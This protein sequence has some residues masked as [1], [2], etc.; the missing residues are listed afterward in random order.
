[1]RCIAIASVEEAPGLTERRDRERQSSGTREATT[2]PPPVTSPAYSY[3][4]DVTSIYTSF[5]A[6]KAHNTSSLS[7]MPDDQHHPPLSIA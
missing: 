1:M 7:I 3:R 4:I 2:T 6:G 5:E